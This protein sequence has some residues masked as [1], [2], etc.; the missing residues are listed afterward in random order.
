MKL[1]V[2]LKIKLSL[3]SRY[4]ERISQDEDIWRNH[5]INAI[6]T[7]P[8]SADDIHQKYLKLLSHLVI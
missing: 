2:E 3:F 6:E 5:E 7:I 1:Y 8:K 4:Y